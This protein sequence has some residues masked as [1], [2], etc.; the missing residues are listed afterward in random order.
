MRYSLTRAIL[1]HLV[2]SGKLMI[3]AFFPKYYPGTG[4]VRGLFGLDPE[5]HPYRE[6]SKASLSSILWRLKRD[7][8]VILVGAR[9]KAAWAV[10]KK[11]RRYLGASKPRLYRFERILLPPDGVLRLVTFDVPERE[12]KKR[13]W[14]RGELIACGFDPLHKSVFIGN[15]ALPEDMIKRI[16]ELRLG[17]YVHIVS[18][19]QSGTLW[20]RA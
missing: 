16:D 7:G 18:I 17:K 11:G 14:L 6:V 10:T 5:H 8:L 20:K 3:D 13:H 4:L 9:G 1:E 15:R 12:R 2:E 19:K